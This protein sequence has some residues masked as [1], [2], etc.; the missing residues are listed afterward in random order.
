MSPLNQQISWIGESVG[1]ED[2]LDQL[3]E[4]VS[5]GITSKDHKCRFYMQ[6]KQNPKSK[7]EE[8]GQN[9]KLDFSQNVHLVVLV[10]HHK[11]RFYMKNQPFKWVER[12]WSK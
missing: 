4:I 12:N 3:N 2:Q 5:L 8:I 9:G 6:N 7:L 11:F 10:I 1:S